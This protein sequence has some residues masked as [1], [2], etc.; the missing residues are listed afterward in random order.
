LLP[1]P[2]QRP[3]RA[4]PIRVSLAQPASRRARCAARRHSSPFPRL[5][6]PQITSPAPQNTS[7]A[8]RVF[9]KSL[10]FPANLAS[11]CNSTPPR[12]PLSACLLVSLSLYL[13]HRRLPLPIPGQFLYFPARLTAEQGN[14]TPPHGGFPPV[15][16]TFP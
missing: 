11:F 16:P 5:T 9:Q 10:V 4:A 1:S 14:Q 8:P 2:P 3:L 15:F 13:F 12:T 6:A 7:P